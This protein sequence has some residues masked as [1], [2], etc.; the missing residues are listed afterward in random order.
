MAPQDRPKA[1]V[2]WSSGK[3]SAYALHL[4]RTAGSHDVVGL[5][6]T[7]TDAYGRVSMHGVREDILD[8]QADRAGLPLTKVRIPSPCPDDIYERAMAEALGPLRDRGVTH[9][10]F[11]DL[12]LADIRAWREERL[13]AVG[14]E[15]V[16]PLW[17]RPT[18]GLIRDMIADG[19]EARIV[20]LDPKHLPRTF[21][22]RGLDRELVAALPPA[23]DPCGEN[24]EF[25]TLVTGG[26]M[27]SRNI[28]VTPGEIVT[29][30]GFV[31][32]DMRLNLNA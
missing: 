13:A 15:G 12:F 25:H 27:F 9:V 19:I 31:F 16:F 10:I 21:A 2:A 1:I 22:G 28:A 4:V 32:A 6:T 3:D 11:G 26:P 29:R 24:G 7:V 30:D 14:L 8:L 17:G 18:T 20:C 5:L 23:V